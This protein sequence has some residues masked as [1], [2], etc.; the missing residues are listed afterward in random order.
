MVFTR[1]GRTMRL[2][3]IL[4]FAFCLCFC[5]TELLAQSSSR[6]SG[7]RPS[8]R[9]S[10][11]PMSQGRPSRLGGARPTAVPTRSAP[12]GMLN[13]VRSSPVSSRGAGRLPSARIG[14]SSR[15]PRSAPSSA[16]SLGSRGPL[17]LTT[18][19]TAPSKRR[20]P[21]SPKSSTPRSTSALTS[22][23]IDSDTATGLRSWTDASGRY[24]I[25]GTIAA[26]QDGMVWLRREDGRINK[27]AVSQLSQTDQNLLSSR[28]Q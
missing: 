22:L 24:S 11:N 14:S 21:R 9:R 3:T 6:G 27:L 8:A 7:S 1:K 20:A 19:V 5:S 28:I 26:H 4:V 13:S 23:P 17:P 10:I 18:G 12:T 25:R 15:L 16:R 2:P